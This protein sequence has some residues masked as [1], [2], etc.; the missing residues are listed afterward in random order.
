M[1]RQRHKFLYLQAHLHFD[2][3]FFFLY[4]LKSINQIIL[5]SWQTNDRAVVKIKIAFFLCNGKI[6][7]SEDKDDDDKD[8]NKAIKD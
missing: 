5:T 3:R 4:R 7:S 2:T 8:D 6:W 1:K